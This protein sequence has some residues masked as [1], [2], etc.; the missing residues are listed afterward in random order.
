MG[1]FLKYSKNFYFVFTLL[2]IL[3]M[4]FIDSNDFVSQFRLG[5]KLSELKKQKEFYQD[6]KEVIKADREELMSNNDLLEKFARERY[7][8][9]RKT[10]DLYVI[11]KE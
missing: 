3:W 7:L 10:E 11:V 5:S 2:F 6:K 9:K 4:L 1:K 8:M